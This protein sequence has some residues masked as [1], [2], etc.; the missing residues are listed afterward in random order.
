MYEFTKGKLGEGKG[1][2]GRIG[3][4]KSNLYEKN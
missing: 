1:R 3:E 2:K 4:I